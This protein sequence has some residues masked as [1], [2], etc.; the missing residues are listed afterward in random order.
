MFNL[1]GVENQFLNSIENLKLVRE[2]GN[3]DRN[4]GSFLNVMENVCDRFSRKQINVPTEALN[5][6]KYINKQNRPWFDEEWQPLRD[7]LYRELNK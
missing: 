4:I 1:N 5:D 7:R 6:L 2:S 3:I